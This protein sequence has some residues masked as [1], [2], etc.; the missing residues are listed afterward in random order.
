MLGAVAVAAAAGNILSHLL[1]AVLLLL[2]I[3]TGV[4]PAWPGYPAEFF[5]N[6]GPILVCLCASVVYHTFM[7]H[8]KHYMT[9]I[10]LDVRPP[11]AFLHPPH[12]PALQ[13]F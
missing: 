4:L 11:P 5:G 1:P 12:G 10:T 3:L 8:H 7:A 2:V 13:R 6:I 9:W